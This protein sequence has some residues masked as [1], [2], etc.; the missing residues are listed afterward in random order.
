MTVHT[1]N[2]NTYLIIKWKSYKENLKVSYK[3]SQKTNPIKY[4][5]TQNKSNYIKIII[6]DSK[7]T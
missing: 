2:V 6:T 1:L 3:Y 5:K 4:S 7:I